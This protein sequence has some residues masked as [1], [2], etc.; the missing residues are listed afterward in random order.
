[1]KL[2]PIR[3]ED[4]TRKPLFAPGSQLV[5]TIEIDPRDVYIPLLKE[6]VAR[7]AVRTKLDTEHILTLTDRLRKEVDTSQPVP[8][9]IRYERPKVIDGK[10]YKHELVFGFHR[11]YAIL[12]NGF[13]QYVYD[14]YQFGTDG[15]PFLKSLRTLQLKENDPLPQKKSLPDEVANV[16][17]ELIEV[18]ELS[19]D[20]ETIT[21]YVEEVKGNAHF[22]TKKSIVNK[23]LANTGGYRD[24]TAYSF[25]QVKSYLGN[26]DNYDDG[27]E[28]YVTKFEYDVPRGQRGA[29]ILSGYEIEA[30][31][32]AMAYYA[33]DGS[34]TYFNMHVKPPK[35]GDTVEDV[36]VRMIKNI[37]NIEKSILMAADYHRKHG[38]FPWHY[39]NFLPQDNKAGEDCFIP[40]AID[41]KL[42]PQ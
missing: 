27:V 28:E 8:A 5:D 32:Q 12:R 29:T 38:K 14:V 7:N 41:G 40:L 25:E 35:N 13:D 42:P 18:G 20:E 4:L 23:V 16:I 3:K 2:R 9:V 33:K 6:G 26:M 10:V 34:Q 19:N 30:I 37:R 21:E 36:R 31:P 15:Y 39:K 11:Q 24:I 1:M 17:M 22:N